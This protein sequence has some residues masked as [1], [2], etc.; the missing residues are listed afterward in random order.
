VPVIPLPDDPDLAQLRRQAKELRRSVVAGEP[1]AVALATE[2]HGRLADPFPLSAAQFVI[3]R[4]HG[5]PSWP[6]LKAHVELV[7]RLTWRPGDLGPQPEPVDEFL[8]LAC[9]TYA[10]DDPARWA[11]AATLLAADPGIGR[12]TI[13]AAAATAD[14]E[15][16][17]RF[18]GS[19]RGAAT[20]AGGPHR[21]VPL[22]Y[23]AY[24][25]HD[26]AIDVDAVLA[27]AQTLLDAGADPNAGYLWHGM[28]SAFTVLTGVLGEGEQGPRDQPRH[29]HWQRLARV[30]LRAGADANDSQGLYNRMFEPGVEHLE[31]L[32]EF[33]LGRGDGGP[34]RA[35]LGAATQSPEELVGG[36]LRWAAT[37]GM[38]DRVGLLV[39][40]G[41]DPLSTGGGDTRI[42]EAA[43]LAGNHDVVEALRAAGAPAPDLDE[44]DE[45]TALLAA[46]D[47]VTVGAV[48]AAHPER[49]AA[50]KQR[51]PSLVVDAVA[52]D[53]PAAV[54]LLLDLGFDVNQLGRGDQ[55]ANGA[56]DTP[57]HVAA[58]AGRIELARLLLTRGADPTIRDGRFDA[59][60]LGWAENFEQPDMV[61]LLR[62]LTPPTATS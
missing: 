6:R 22:M 37:H 53:R 17:Q 27:T 34:W 50:T 60:P 30:L 14:V 42:L 45:L 31:L 7:N 25:R 23:L 58:G 39:A 16:L 8:R 49:L 40:H 38:V 55:P 18:V 33:G 10:G 62:P 15:A 36:Q 41:A 43:A 13:H 52:A 51:R 59:T 54:E 61:E 4:R 19:D 12:A 28:P 46:G 48:I 2:V 26:P 20:T 5:F 44:V 56:W 29:P 9:L 47:A 32:F 11:Q 1:A 24:A 3:A 57:L 35:R 21:W